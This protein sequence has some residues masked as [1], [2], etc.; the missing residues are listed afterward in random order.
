VIAN[1]GA[2]GTELDHTLRAERGW[3][4]RYVPVDRGTGHAGLDLDRWVPPR[5]WD[6]FA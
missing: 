3:R 6:W 2:G 1:I 4:G 5:R